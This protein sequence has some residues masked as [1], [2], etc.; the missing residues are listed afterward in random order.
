MQTSTWGTMSRAPLPGLGR[1]VLSDEAA[2]V[3]LE[4]FDGEEPRSL[5]AVSHPTSRIFPTRARQFGV[6]GIE[7]C[8][9]WANVRHVLGTTLV[10][11]TGLLTAALLR[12]GRV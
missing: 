9:S 12:P 7:D 5:S 1:Q 11:E 6:H 2:V 3:D 10:Q 4:A 8:A